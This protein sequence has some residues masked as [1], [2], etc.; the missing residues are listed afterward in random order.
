MCHRAV[1]ACIFVFDVIPDKYKTEEICD[2]AVSLYFTFI[3]YC[4]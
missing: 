3:V 1:H 4:P 2:L